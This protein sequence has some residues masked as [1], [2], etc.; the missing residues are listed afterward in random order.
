MCGLLRA[1]LRAQFDAQINRM[2]STTAHATRFDPA[3]PWRA[4][5]LER[6]N[7]RRGRGA[8]S[9]AGRVGASAAALCEGSHR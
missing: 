3:K 8:R 6:F 1:S 2:S 5:A 7:R 9:Y 4:V